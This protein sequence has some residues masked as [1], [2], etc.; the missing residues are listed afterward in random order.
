MVTD[1]LKGDQLIAR[2]LDNS[3]TRP[4]AAEHANPN[5]VRIIQQIKNSSHQ[6]L[7]CYEFG[8]GAGALGQA[9]L[10]TQIVERFAGCDTSKEACQLAQNNGLD[11]ENTT[12]EVVVS[13][14]PRASFQ[15][16][17]LFVYADVLEHLVDPWVHLK[18]LNRKITTGSWIVVS[19]PCF[20]HHS[21]LSSIGRMDFEYE[22]WGVMDITHLRH[23]GLKNIVS[24]L[25]LTG[26][27]ISQDIPIIPSFDPEGAQLYSESKERL[28]I[29][30]KFGDMEMTIRDHQHLLQV[31]AYQF[32]VAAKK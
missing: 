24:L 23:Y 13:S 31:C 26:F 7:K 3:L 21:N 4:Y 25:K 1:R 22:E 28:P 32:I 19:I 17:N 20:F 11:V 5:V 29:Q 30:L 9:L 15:D 14:M 16:F 2:W 12:C 18:E 6:I 10:R 27:R 8:C